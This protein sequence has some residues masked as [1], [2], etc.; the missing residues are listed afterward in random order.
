MTRILVATVALWMGIG[1]ADQATPG[2]GQ[3][4]R[5]APAYLP[6][7][8]PMGPRAAA[9]H[10]YVSAL[11][12]DRVLEQLATDPSLLRPPGAWAPAALLPGDA[13]GQT[14]GYDRARMARLYGSKR[15]LV[16][17]GPKGTEGRPSES[18]TLVSPYPSSDTTRLEP[19][20]MLIIL[21]LEFP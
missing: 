9:Y 19:G 20:T 6:L 21:N 17:R 1:P 5:E 3:L 15:V 4:W 16:A 14:G 8:A 2:P 7:F 13:F 12:L 11:A 10:I 18:W